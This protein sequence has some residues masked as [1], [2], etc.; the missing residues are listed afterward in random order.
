MFKKVE[1]EGFEDNPEL[2]TMARQATVVLGGVIRDWR[3]DVA[4]VWRPT[5]VGTTE[6]LELGLKLVLPDTSAAAAG[7]IRARAF[8]PGEET[9]LRMDVREVWLD[10]LDR[11]IA[12][13]AARVEESFTTPVEV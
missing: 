13:V 12:Q 2:E 8:K 10:L 5:E 4:V 11:L 6:E 9:L 3:D 1:F 7:R